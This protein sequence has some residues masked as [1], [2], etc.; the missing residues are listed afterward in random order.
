MNVQDVV[1]DL[2]DAIAV[3]P[4]KAGMKRRRCRCR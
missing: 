1:A 4:A 3:S 2:F